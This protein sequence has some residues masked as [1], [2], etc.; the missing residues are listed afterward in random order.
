MPRGQSEGTHSRQQPRL[1]DSYPGQS[2]NPRNCQARSQNKAGRLRTGPPPPESGSGDGQSRKGRSARRG[3]PPQAAGRLL[4]QPRLLGILDDWH[5]QEGGSRRPAPRNR[6]RRAHCRPRKPGG[7]DGGGE[8]PQPPTGATRPP[9][10]W[11]PEPPGPAARSKRRPSRVCASVEYPRTG[12][13][14][15]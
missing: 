11:S 13:S 2:P 4:G 3:F 15:A 14:A 6:H 8:K 5:R 10:A 1:W 7:R 9:S 12:A